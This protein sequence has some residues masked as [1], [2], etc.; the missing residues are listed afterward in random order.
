MNIL[1]FIKEELGGIWRFLKRNGN[2]TV[3]LAAATLFLALHHYHPI[4]PEWLSVFLYCGIFPVLVVLLILRK[5]PL[6]Y[7]LRWGIP[8]LWGYYVLIICVAAA[9][10]LYASSF[11]TSLQSYY[12]NAEF[13]IAVYVLTQ[14]VSLCGWEF[15]FRGFLLF[16]LK[17]KLGEAS[18]LVQMVPFVLLHIGKPEVETI[19]TIITGILFGYVVYRGRSF[20]PAFFIHLFINIFFVVLVNLRYPAAG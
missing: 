11:F 14:A 8:R 3:V 18:I 2:E 1:Q 16:G 13:N 17:E 5:N 10:I 19:S 20:W 6:D 4:G 9:V 12:K 15:M 7:G